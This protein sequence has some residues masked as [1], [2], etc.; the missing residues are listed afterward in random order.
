MRRVLITGAN[1]FIGANLARRMLRDGADVHLLVRPGFSDWRIRDIKT[2]LP[3]HE[4]PLYDAVAVRSCVKEVRPQWIFH[5]AA[6]GAYSWQTDAEQMLKTNLLGTVNLSEACAAVGFDAFVY[7]GSSSEYG[8]KDHAPGERELADPT[9]IY[10]ASKL[11]ATQY[12]SY[13]ARQRDL[14]IRTLR[15]YS[16]Y[17][18]YE[19]PKRLLPRLIVKG[20]SG[21]LPHLVDAE[22]A[23]DFV[24]IDDV[25]DAIVAAASMAPIRDG[26]DSDSVYNVGTGTQTKIKELV[27]L[28]RRL[29]SIAEEPHWGSMPNRTWDTTIWVADTKRIHKDLGWQP[30][31]SLEQGFAAAV[32]W[33]K[34]HP[35]MLEYYR[36]CGKTEG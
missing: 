6:H 26:Q 9:S 20:L 10:G 12:C 18:A 32:E 2:S 30:Q 7:S 24:Y 4:V 21:S 28:A 36:S 35:D 23:R 3:I 8:L 33:F 14:P 1:G 11:A 25:L 31:F 19:D 17:G 13:L 15:L 34:S 16:V 27:A 22:V 29:L 5:L